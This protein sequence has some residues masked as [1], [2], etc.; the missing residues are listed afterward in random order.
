[1]KEVAPKDWKNVKRT[2]KEE[3]GHWVTGLMYRHYC[4]KGPQLN[5]KSYSLDSL[6]SLISI[7]KFANLKKRSAFP[8]QIK[9]QNFILSSTLGLSQNHVNAKMLVLLF[10][11]ICSLSE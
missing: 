5:I 3:I 10:L 2:K 7:S 11:F 6:S 8:L 1:M 4:K 9:L